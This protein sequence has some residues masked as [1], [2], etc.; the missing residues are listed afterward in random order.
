[1]P[2]LHKQ[3]TKDIPIITIIAIVPSPIEVPFYYTINV[4]KD[5]VCLI[6]NYQKLLAADASLK[7]A[8]EKRSIVHILVNDELFIIGLFA[9]KIGSKIIKN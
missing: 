5:E 7:L 1:M 6:I 8:I 4:W 3:I 2:L 9:L